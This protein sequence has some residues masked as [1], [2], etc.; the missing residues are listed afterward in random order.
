MNRYHIGESLLPALRYHLRFIDV[1]SVFESRDFQKKVRPCIRMEIQAYPFA[2]TKPGR[3][4]PRSNLT[5]VIVKAVRHLLFDFDYVLIWIQIPTSWHPSERTNT[6]G[7]SCDLNSMISSSGIQVNVVLKF[8]TP[9]KWNRFSLKTTETL[10]HRVQSGHHT[11]T[12]LIDHQVK[13]LSNTL[14]TP[15]DAL[16]L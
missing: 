9:P 8:T 13:Y 14:S 6:S 4:E 15:P 2:S 16:V 11:L 7:T 1:D 10:F 3:P 12:G 5:R